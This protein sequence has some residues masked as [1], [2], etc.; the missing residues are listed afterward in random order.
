V[1]PPPSLV[2]PDLSPLWDAVRDRL[3]RLGSARRGR[4]RI[5]TLSTEGRQ[6]L[7]SLLGRSLTAT[8]DL[9][10]LERALDRVGAGPDLVSALAGVGHAMS[11]GNEHRRADRVLRR[12][13]RDAARCEVAGWPEE[14]AA[15]WIN[16]VIQA[17]LLRGL[18]TDG[19]TDLVKGVRRCLDALASTDQPRSRVDLAA[20]VL[21]DSHAL[22]PGTRLGAS[23]MRGLRQHYATEL[24]DDTDRTVW[25]RAGAPSDSVSAPVLTWNLPV[26][27]TGELFAMVSTATALGVVAHLSQM[28]LRAG[29][30]QV[31]PGAVVLVTENPRV[32]EAAA[33]RVSA[34]SVVSTNGNPSTAV[35]LLL[36]QLLES[37]AEVR[38][39]GDFDAAGLSICRRLAEFGLVP[40]RMNVEDYERAVAEANTQGVELP[41]DEADPGPTPWDQPLREVFRNCRRVVHE[42][43]LLGELLGS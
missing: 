25:D 39:H 15:N 5:P 26:V 34:L 2:G 22:D 43:R 4:L 1:T 27:A 38:Y 28:A 31:P 29:P 42:E 30:V 35:R 20:S 24:H 23:V 19:A 10:E 41:F 32:V 14:W 3:E 8:L 6:H 16:E 7:T 18:D 12:N 40:W 36:S 9:G 17:G 21:G 37:G 33:Q 13:A 11:F